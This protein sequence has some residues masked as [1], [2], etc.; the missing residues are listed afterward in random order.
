MEKNLKKRILT[1]IV[2]FLFLFFAF[3]NNFVLGYLLMIISVFSVLEFVKMMKIF[4]K[5]N[6][7][8][9]LLSNLVFICYI[10]CYWD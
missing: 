1:S 2:L 4:L 3:I 9:Q 6:I 8:L 5:S 10:F 7:A